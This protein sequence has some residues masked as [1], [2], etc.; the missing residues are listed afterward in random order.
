MLAA[1][2]VPAELTALTLKVWVPLDKPVNVCCN[3]VPTFVHVMLF[4]DTSYLVIAAPPLFVGADQFILTW[5]VPGVALRLLG[6]P[7]T[8]IFASVVNTFSLLCC[9]PVKPVA[10][11]T[12]RTRYVELGV[13]PVIVVLKLLLVVFT[14]TSL[15]VV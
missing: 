2:P 7:G 15:W 14:H 9:V 13:S 3:A 12:A 11:D 4:E 10:L 1:V 6:A 5:F 8:V